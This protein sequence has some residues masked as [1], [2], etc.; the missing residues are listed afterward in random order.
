MMLAAIIWVIFFVAFGWA[1][2][3]EIM[4]RHRRE[5]RDAAKR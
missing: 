5:A 1:Q 2:V 4:D 3:A